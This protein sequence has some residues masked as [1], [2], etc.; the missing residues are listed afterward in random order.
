MPR[1]S[2]GQ[3]LALKCDCLRAAGRNYGLLAKAD[4][5]QLKNKY[6]ISHSTVYHHWNEAKQMGMGGMYPYYFPLYFPPANEQY[7]SMVGA[8]PADPEAIQ[9]PTNNEA[10]PNQTQNGGNN[11]DSV[12]EA[13]MPAE[14]SDSESEG[15]DR[16]PEAQLVPPGAMKSKTNQT[17]NGGDDNDSVKEAELSDSESGGDDQKSAAKPVPLGTTNSKTKARSKPPADPYQYQTRAD[18]PPGSGVVKTRGPDDRARKRIRRES[19]LVIN[20]ALIGAR[21]RKVR[22]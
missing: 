16:K 1:L 17:Q 4:L 7:F 18:N 22:I 6:A 20:T 15:D 12:K 10:V 9:V 8:S 2:P 21:V 19:D 11:N 5:E 14:L 3:V 13:D